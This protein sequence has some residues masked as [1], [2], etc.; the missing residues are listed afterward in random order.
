MYRL[1][2]VVE[3]KGKTEIVECL[4][5]TYELQRLKTELQSLA[6]LKHFGTYQIVE[7]IL[8]ENEHTQRNRI[9][10]YPIKS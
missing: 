9:E 10:G 6:E 7:V 3:F 2:R 8:I 5:E 1:E 4:K